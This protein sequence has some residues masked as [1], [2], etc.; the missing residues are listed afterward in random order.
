MRGDGLSL[1]YL[2][3]ASFVFFVCGV[4]FCF[5]VDYIVEFDYLS[6]DGRV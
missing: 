4:I 6:T 2:Y 5:D 3:V 1:F